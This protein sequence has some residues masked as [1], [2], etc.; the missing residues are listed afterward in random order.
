MTLRTNNLAKALLR[1]EAECSDPGIH[2][3]AN[4]Q[5]GVP[6]VLAPARGDWN[7]CG[8][9][10]NGEKRRAVRRCP[11]EWLKLDRFALRQCVVD[12]L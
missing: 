11:S 3:G 6:L 5:N 8:Y 1:H 4:L 2:L 7:K 10:L 12:I 9:R